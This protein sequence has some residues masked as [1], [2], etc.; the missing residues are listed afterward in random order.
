MSIES[1][2]SGER[3]AVSGLAGLYVLRMLGLFMVLPV[4]SIYSADLKGATPALIGMAIG[5]YGLTQALLQIPFG[6]LSDKIG[7]KTVIV[8]GLLL[9]I[10]GSIVAAM[11]ESIY[12]V[13]MGRCLQGSGAIAS[14]VMALLS[15]LTREQMRMRAMAVVGISIGLSFS[16]ALVLGPVISQPYG[17]EGLFWF[18]ALLASV[19]LAII[20][21]WVPTPQRYDKHRDT[22]VQKGQ[23][24]KILRHPELLRLDFGI[25]I[26][27]LIMTAT[28][29]V[30]PLRMIELDLMV[31]YHWIVYL[32]VMILSFLAMIPFI[33]VAEKKRKM[34]PIFIFAIALVALAQLLMGSLTADS[35]IALF[36]LL[37]VYFMAFNLLEASLPSLVSKLSPA[38]QKGAAMGVYSS[39]QF[40]GAFVGGAAGGW[41]YGVWGIDAVLTTCGVLAF[42]WA[43]V[44]L[45]MAPPKHLTGKAVP[46]PEHW[47]QDIDGFVAKLLALPGVEEV[48]VIEEEHAAYM[49]IDKAYFDDEALAGAI[50]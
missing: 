11:S 40:F 1:M 37:F 15:D 22:G 18:T 49:K 7:R 39:S 10:A 34:K 17:L 2:T 28:F 3:R 46:L 36:L 9:F 33:I 48:V 41:L 6:F 30:I 25:F 31:Q 16:V 4:L 50:A 19:G 5:G 32:P 29:V 24:K 20:W 13:I 8:F 21:K 42:V 44:V 38:G 23:L 45:P 43:V 26:L 35:R 47:Q 12:G 14:S 27:H